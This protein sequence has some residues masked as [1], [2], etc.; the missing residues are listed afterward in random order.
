MTLLLNN[1]NR[2]CIVKRAS[3]KRLSDS[4]ATFINNNNDNNNNNNNNSERLHSYIVKRWREIAP[5]VLTNNDNSNSDN[6]NK[7]NNYISISSCARVIQS[8]IDV[9]FEVD[10]N[11]NDGSSMIVTPQITLQL[12]TSEP[13]NNKSNNKKIK[14]SDKQLMNDIM[15]TSNSSFLLNG[16]PQLED[17]HKQLQEMSNAVKALQE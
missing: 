14:N 11:S 2:C 12:K 16:L 13:Q 4:L 3:P 17:L 7:N 9:G 8:A 15:S 10:N 1:N 6:D 5:L